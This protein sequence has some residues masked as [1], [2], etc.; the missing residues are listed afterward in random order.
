[1]ALLR[2]KTYL[3]DEVLLNEFNPVTAVQRS[4]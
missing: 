4:S 1:M 2:E 3:K